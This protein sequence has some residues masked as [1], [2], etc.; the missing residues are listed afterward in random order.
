MWKNDFLHCLE[1]P[2]TCSSKHPKCCMRGTQTLGTQRLS[3]LL[4]ATQLVRSKRPDWNLHFSTPCS[5]FCFPPTQSSNFTLRKLIIGCPDIDLNAHISF[6]LKAVNETMASDGPW[7]VADRTVMSLRKPSMSPTWTDVE[8]LPVSLISLS[9]PSL[10]KCLPHN[11]SQ[12]RRHIFWFP[13]ALTQAE[14][15][16]LCFGHHGGNYMLLSYPQSA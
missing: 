16:H 1:F 4:M 14:L 13:V 12:P 6:G 15:T 10:L 8:V 11:F 2:V 3:E 5:A 9:L 7:P